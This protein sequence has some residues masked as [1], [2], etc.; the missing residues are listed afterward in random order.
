[1]DARNI[2]KSAAAMTVVCGTVFL[3]R[4]WFLRGIGGYTTEIGTPAILNFHLLATLNALLFRMWGLLLFPLN[5]AVLPGTLLILT[6]LLMLLAAALFLLFSRAN[7]SHLL[8][9]LGLILAAALPVQHLLLIGPDFAGARVLYLPTLG[10]ALFFGLVFEGC[11]K[12]GFAAILGACVLLFQWGALDHNLRVRTE[13]AE[14]SR[15]VCMA[16]G[17]EL[18]RDP[19]YVLAEELPRTWKGVYF[20]STGFIPCVAIQSGDPEIA[21]RL[22]VAP[23]TTNTPLPWRIFKWSA[24]AQTLVDADPPPR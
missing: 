17:E 5:W 13:T 12:P 10:L 23:A 20:L 3:Y 22:F 16:L 7:R 4:A 9:S 11:D 6:S 8:A 15:R 24:T 19:R 14:L 21:D 2:A 1:L 18:R